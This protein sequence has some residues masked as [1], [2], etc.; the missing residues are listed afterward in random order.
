MEPDI[1]VV[2]PAALNFHSLEWNYI[3]AR[4]Q[5]QAGRLGRVD[6]QTGGAECL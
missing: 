2:R 5:G 6:G 1:A 3:G 4:A